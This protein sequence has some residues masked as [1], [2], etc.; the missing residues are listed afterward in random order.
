MT[1]RSP[2]LSAA[3]A[4]LVREILKT[5]DDVSRLR[6]AAGRFLRAVRS[7]NGAVH[8]ASMDSLQECLRQAQI[9]LERGAVELERV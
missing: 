3:G 6:L 9:S 7:E 8:H 1:T 2:R 4:A 5:T